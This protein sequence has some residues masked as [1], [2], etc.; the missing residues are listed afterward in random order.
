MDDGPD[1]VSPSNCPSKIDDGGCWYKVCFH[2]EEV[3]DLVDGKPD[4]RQ[5]SD[6]KEEK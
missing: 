4:S 1:S 3:T 2:G 5:R 6:P